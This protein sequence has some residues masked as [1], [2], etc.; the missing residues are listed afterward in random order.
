MRVKDFAVSALLV[1]ATSPAVAQDAGP[2]L[3]LCPP[4]IHR[5]CFIGYVTA[6]HKVSVMLA[7][8]DIEPLAGEVAVDPL[9]LSKE[10]GSVVMLDA[11]LKGTDALANAQLVFVADPLLTA[12]YVNTFSIATPD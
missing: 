12:I 6:S 11:T 8:V 10:I 4:T 9:D 2:Q 5:A 1:L 7:S 3:N